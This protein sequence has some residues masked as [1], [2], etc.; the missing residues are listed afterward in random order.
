MDEN[1]KIPYHVAIIMDGNRRW[2]RERGLPTIEGHRAGY[3]NFKKIVDLCH[4]KGVKILTVFAFS[5]ENW[6]RSK[7]EVNYLMN[8]LEE[9][10]RSEA[11]FFNERNIRFNPIGRLADL[12]NHLLKTVLELKEKTAQNTEG[13]LNLA[14]SYGGRAEIVEACK[15]II[16][17]RISSQEISEEVFAKY[18][19]TAGQP[20][21]DIIIRTGGRKR[22]SNFLLFQSAYSEIYFTD[23]YWPSFD[24]QELEKAF[25]FFRNQVRTFGK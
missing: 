23:V 20:D 10:L 24:E 6:Q 12:P 14:L 4:K 25:E 21:P 19:Y 13:I 16:E 1:L 17:D 8:L 3:Q 9:G 7:E 5:T 18:L 15:K 2:A 11:K 22:I